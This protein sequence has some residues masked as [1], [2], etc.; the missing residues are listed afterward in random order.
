[1]SAAGYRDLFDDAAAGARAA[2]VAEDLY[3]KGRRAGFSEL[4]FRPMFAFLKFYLLKGNF[5]D[6]R[7]GL[8]V[9]ERAAIGTR[10]KYVALSARQSGLV[11]RA[12]AS[13]SPD[14]KQHS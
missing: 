12:D 1:V 4:W 14:Q 3:R 6:G 7:F 5:L 13:S 9:A 8:M 2:I 11:R 10:Q